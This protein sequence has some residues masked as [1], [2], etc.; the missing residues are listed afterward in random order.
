MRCLKVELGVA[1]TVSPRRDEEI[2]ERNEDPKTSDVEVVD[3]TRE[4]WF[5]EDRRT[6]TC[7]VPTCERPSSTYTQF[8]EDVLTKYYLIFSQDTSMKKLR[9]KFGL[10]ICEGWRYECTVT[11]ELEGRQ[12]IEERVIELVIL[13]SSLSALALVV[14]V[15]NNR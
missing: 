11:V 3:L 12:I 10:K 4:V 1:K 8:G 15:Q 5:Q 13:P 7:R 6:V 14:I 9:F 2:G